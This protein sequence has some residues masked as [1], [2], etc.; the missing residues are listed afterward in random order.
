[1]HKPMLSAAHATNGHAESWPRL[2]G[3]MQ[4]SI[5]E[6]NIGD[7]RLTSYQTMAQKRQPPSTVVAAR[8]MGA[9]LDLAPSSLDQRALAS[10]RGIHWRNSSVGKSQRLT[11]PSQ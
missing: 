10:Y 6:S 9:M 5:V 4:G 1:M 3:S 7:A 2:S 8:T 11:F